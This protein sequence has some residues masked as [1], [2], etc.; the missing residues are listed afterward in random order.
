M[1]KLIKREFLQVKEG[2]NRKRWYA[3]MECQRC[4]KEFTI[5]ERP[6]DLHLRKPCETCSRQIISYKRFIEKAIVKHRKNFDYSLVTQDNYVNLF[7]PIKIICKQHGVFQQKPKDHISKTNGKICCPTCIQEFN[8]IHN[9]R[10]IESW[11]E[12]L[13]SKTP[14]ITFKE[15]GNADS[16][17]EKCVLSCKYH[18]DFTTTLASI[19]KN[20]YICHHCATEANSWSERTK[21]I[22]I[23]GTIYH[24]YLPELNMYKLGVT[25]TSI[26]ERF[27]QL[28]Y[29]YKI[30]WEQEL[31]TLK[32]AF[33]LEAQLFRR[34]KDYR[35]FSAYKLPSFEPFGG[36]TELLTCEI[37]ITA[38]QCSNTLS[39]EP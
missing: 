32:E 17:L 1:N 23:P 38:L 6:Q 28:S 9:K 34:Y 8:K 31:N 25:T 20:V 10:T 14:H 36:Y 30:L 27:R 11:K 18:G 29:T 15:H 37:P 7:T 39:K 13:L 19:K 3:T 24:I 26:E 12:E 5:R 33:L 35:P 21:R 16:N 22:D 4:K 2:E